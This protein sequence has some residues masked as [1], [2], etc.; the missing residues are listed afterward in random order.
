MS[1]LSRR[2]AAVIVRYMRPMQ[3][4]K[5]TV[6]IKEADSKNT[7]VTMLALEGLN[8][9]VLRKYF[10]LFNREQLLDELPG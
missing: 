9:D 10:A 3:V 7:G 1:Q 8:M 2:D 6:F 5:G 4:R